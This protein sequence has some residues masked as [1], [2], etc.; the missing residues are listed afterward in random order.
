MGRISGTLS[1]YTV[2]TH[3]NP[4]RE[5]GLKILQQIEQGLRETTQQYQVIP[6][7]PDAIQ[8]AL[9]IAKAGDCVLVAGK[10]HETTQ[11]FSDRTLPFNDTDFLIQECNAT[12]QT[13]TIQTLSG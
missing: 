7:R 5:D 10:G 2:V 11:I 12:R 8:H 13:S 9:S 3:D 6:H 4:K 1:D